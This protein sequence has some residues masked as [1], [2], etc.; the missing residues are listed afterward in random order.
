MYLHL[1]FVLLLLISSNTY[2]TSNASSLSPITDENSHEFDVHFPPF[3]LLGLI[4]NG[5][6]EEPPQPPNLRK[7]VIIRGRYSLPKWE[8]HGL[9]EYI[10][11]GPQ[12][13][14]FY[15]PVPRGDEASISQQLPL[16]PGSYYS[17]TFAATRTCAQ[18]EVLGVKAG[19]GSA[20]LTIK[21]CSVGVEGTFM[22]TSALVK[23][24][25]HN[26]GVQ[27]D[28]ACGPLLDA[29]AVKEILPL[30]HTKGNLVKNGDFE[31]GPYIFKNF[32]IGVLL[33][34]HSL[35]AISP[36]P[37]W[38]VESLKPVKYI[39]SKHFF[40]PSGHAA[41]ELVGGRESTTAQIIRTVPNKSYLLTFTIGDARN[42]C[43]GSMMVEA[44]AGKETIKVPLESQGKGDFKSAS[45]K[46]EAIS[47]RTR[48]TFWSAFYHTKVHDYAYLCGPVLDDVKVVPI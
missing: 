16:K 14:G 10:S 3:I 23:V 11:R 28:P 19:K 46:F 24:T 7:K 35:D 32:S 36:L 45:F 39:D 31:I 22:D 1:G 15:F 9:V 41:I 6:F 20:D 21:H 26:P 34:P 13:G 42:G 29:I 8:I 5:N 12:P 47:T 25:F 33:P 38:I 17:L 4:P 27:E 30:C 40:V 2:M 48:I 43:N 18:D 37:G 44:F